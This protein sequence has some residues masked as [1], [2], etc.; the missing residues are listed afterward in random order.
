[1]LTLTQIN[2]YPVKSLDGYSPE[3]AIVEKRG[4]Q[5]DR[6]WLIVNTEGVFLTQR[7]VGRMALLKAIIE[8]N[9]LVIFEKNEPSHRISIPL[10]INGVGE[11]LQVQVWNDIMT[12][13]TVS[14]EADNFLSDFLQKPC[15]L[16]FMPD[17]TERIVDVAYNT[18]NDIVSFADGYPLLLIGEASLADLNEKILARSVAHTGIGEAVS[19]RRFRPNLVFSGGHPFQEDSLIDFKIGAI[20]FI[21]VKPCVRCA[22]PNRDPDTGIKGKEP[23]ETLLTYRQFEHKILFGQNVVWD[24]RKWTGASSPEIKVGDELS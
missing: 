12:A 16:V 4:L 1:M 21:G 6:R 20:D 24:F 19:M 10:S 3:K 8:E 5:Y 17:T 9:Q 22:L 2:I 11:T 15:R 14:A 23:I 13:Q 18:G 7:T